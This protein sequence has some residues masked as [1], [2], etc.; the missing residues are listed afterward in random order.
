PDRAQDRIAAGHYDLSGQTIRHAHGQ[1]QTRGAHDSRGIDRAHRLVRGA[2]QI[3]GS[4]AAQDADGIRPGNDAGDGRLLGHRKLLAPHRARARLNGPAAKSS[5]WSFARP[6]SSIRKP[7]SN[8]SKDRL[9]IS[10]KKRA[11]GSNRRSVFW[12]P[13]SPNARRRN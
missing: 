5:N 4:P 2:R 8:R 6:A 13:L 9:T 3:A 7:P 10:L 12:S 1:N 11:S